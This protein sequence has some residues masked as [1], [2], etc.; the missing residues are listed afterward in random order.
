[1]ARA[2]RDPE[3]GIL[4]KPKKCNQPSPAELAKA[5]AAVGRRRSGPASAI[6]GNVVWREYIDTCADEIKSG[7]SDMSLSQIHDGLVLHFKYPYSYST[8][9]EYIYRIHGKPRD[10][11][12]G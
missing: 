4:Q 5:D 12:N 6:A 1:M 9:R 8:V 2:K 10:W 11:A 3:T 7:R